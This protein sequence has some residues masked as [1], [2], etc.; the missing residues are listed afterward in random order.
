[1]ESDVLDYFALG[2]HGG[3]VGVTRVPESYCRWYDVQGQLPRFVPSELTES[4]YVYITNS[5]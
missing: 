5:L 4:A 2:V 3:L 1:M